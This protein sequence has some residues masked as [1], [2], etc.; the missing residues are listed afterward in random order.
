M[1][2]L[3][4]AFI[5]QLLLGA[6]AVFDKILLGRKRFD[7]LTYAFW[8]GILGF[9]SL[10]FVFF[11]FE[12]ISLI[13]F[14]SAAVGG[15]V[16]ILA[17][18]FSLVALNKGD[19]VSILILVGTLSPIFTLILSFAILPYKISSGELIGFL[20]LLAGALILFISSE[21]DKFTFKIFGAAILSAF[22]FAISN[23]F[24]KVAFDE[25]SFATVFIIAKLS[26]AFFAILFLLFKK[27]KEN[28]LSSHR[29]STAKYNLAYFLNRAVAGI[30]SVLI[31][32]AI[33][34]GHPALADATQG[35]RYSVIFIMSWLF[36]KERPGIFR[37]F[38]RLL[39]TCFVIFGFL[40]LALIQYAHN[41]PAPDSSRPINWGIT[42]STKISRDLGLDWKEN[43]LSILND[44]KPDGMRLIAYW[45]EVEPQESVLNFESLDWQIDEALK[46][47]TDVILVLGMK[48]PRWPECNIPEWAK[49]LSPQEQEAKLFV[50][51]KKVIERY[52]TN[53]EIKI[54]QVENEPFLNFGVCPDR[55]EGFLDREVALVKSIDSSR[56][57]LTTDG[58]EFGDWYRS[59]KRGDIF[60]TTM[61]RRVYP[62]IIGPIFGIVEYPLSAGYFRVKEKIIKLLLPE[63]LNQ[64][65]I[66]VELQSEPWLLGSFQNTPIDE[67]YK[68]FD[69][70]YFKE[71]LE[72]AK[73]A[74]FSDYYFWGVEW[75]YWLKTK[76]ADPSF[77][78]FGKEIINSVP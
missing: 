36:L 53:P 26:G 9:L 71:T 75:W 51:V 21:K 1:N 14:I 45:D 13:G 48:T 8:I 29:R 16:F 65:F 54:W 34:K 68:V 20:I 63:K 17:V 27:T 47:G 76:H 31:Y 38:L 56:S 70:E 35:L 67:Q 12:P 61:Y 64:K 7:P 55:P 4:I 6:A 30:G 15:V 49:N 62:R 50:Y 42:F 72:Y 40:F 39:A 11:G 33:S 46:S 43:Y 57:I 60:G 28:I 78:N 19:A 10:F 74:N 18:Y 22:L 77:W 73:K 44:L 32:V 3:W 58:G 2:W 37:T 25:S 69:L 59:A 24:S 52:K 66:V 23:V 41:L 5:A